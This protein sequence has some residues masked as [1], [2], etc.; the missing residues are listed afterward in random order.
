VGR[1]YGEQ[2]VAASTR[3]NDRMRVVKGDLSRGF[4]LEML[5]VQFIAPFGSDLS[6]RD[7][8][9]HQLEPPEGEVIAAIRAKTSHC[10]ASTLQTF[11]ASG[12]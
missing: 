4:S 8:L 6:R 9:R 3:F 5:Q 7:A 1:S 11:G 12:G 2:R 10:K